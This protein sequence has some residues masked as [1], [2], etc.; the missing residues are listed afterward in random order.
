LMLILAIMLLTQDQMIQR[1]VKTSYR[2][3]VA[4]TRSDGLYN[5][6]ATRS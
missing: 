1:E 3:N 5:Q 6:A 2:D 4:Y